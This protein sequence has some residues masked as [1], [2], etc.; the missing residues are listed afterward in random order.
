MAKSRNPEVDAEV[1]RSKYYSPGGKPLTGQ[2]LKDT[3]EGDRQSMDDLAD[4]ERY[5]EKQMQPAATKPL[6]SFKKGGTVSKTGTYKL[7]KG[8]RVM[9]VKRKSAAPRKR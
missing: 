7:H 1:D 5:G 6:G 8:E 9:P 4:D 3:R 2:R